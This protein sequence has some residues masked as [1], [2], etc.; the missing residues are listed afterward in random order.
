MTTRIRMTRP[1]VGVVT[2]L[3]V[4]IVVAPLVLTV[5]AAIYNA[6]FPGAIMTI[7]CDGAAMQTVAACRPAP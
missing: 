2:G 6:V 7:Q 3:A 1:T 5:A 4:G